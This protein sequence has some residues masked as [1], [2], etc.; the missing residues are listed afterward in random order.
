M[1]L[2]LSTQGFLHVPKEDDQLN[3]WTETWFL[4]DPILPSLKD[5]VFPR[6]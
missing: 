4:I 5:E 1:L 6:V 3:L 2:V